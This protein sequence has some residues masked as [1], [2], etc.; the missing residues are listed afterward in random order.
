MS[1]EVAKNVPKNKFCKKILENDEI[2]LKSCNI[3][4]S[5]N[6]K[7][8]EYDTDNLSNKNISNCDKNTCVASCSTYDKSPTTNSC[9]VSDDENIYTMTNYGAIVVRFYDINIESLCGS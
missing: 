7:Y 9:Y 6:A 2:R 5:G 8:C 3:S 4:C 1:S